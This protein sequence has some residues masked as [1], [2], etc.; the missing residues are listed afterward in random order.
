LN[1]FGRV[2]KIALV[3]LPKF[4]RRPFFDGNE[5]A[6]RKELGKLL[7]RFRKDAG[8]TQA[9]VARTLGYEQQGK[10][11]QLETAKRTLDPIEL[12]NFARLYQKSLND[13]STWRHD[14]PSTDELRERASRHHTEALK[15]QRRYYKK[16][17][18]NEDK[19]DGLGRRVS[20]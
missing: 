9:A 20:R 7:R 5:S 16:R 11:S 8:L 14:Q 19:E 13:F 15:F 10:I 18:G 2:H 4:T 17:K 12:E 6:R 3:A 1:L